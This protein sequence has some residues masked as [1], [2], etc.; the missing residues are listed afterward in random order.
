MVP[1]HL[2]LQLT[3]AARVSKHSMSVDVQLQYL[4][5]DSVFVFVFATTKNTAEQ[6][7][8]VSTGHRPRYYQLKVILFYFLYYTT[9]RSVGLAH[10]PTFS[11]GTRCP[12]VNAQASGSQ[13]RHRGGA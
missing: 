4:R 11:H 1:A 13:A 8:A 3:G 2:T 10:C 12:N 7:A 5:G 9:Q 6:H